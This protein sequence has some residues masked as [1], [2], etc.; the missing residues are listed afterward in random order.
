MLSKWLPWIVLF[1]AIAKV[2]EMI[3]HRTGRR[4][5]PGSFNWMIGLMAVAIGLAVTAIVYQLYY[6]K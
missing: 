2:G 4:E 3:W 5:R 6:Q 1:V